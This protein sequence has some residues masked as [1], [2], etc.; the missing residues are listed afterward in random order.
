MLI[1]CYLSA[2]SDVANSAIV[3]DRQTARS[4]DTQHM[5]ETED[6]PVRQ[7]KGLIVQALQ[8]HNENNALVVVGETGSGKT[9]QVPQILLDGSSQTNLRNL[10]APRRIAVTQPRRVAAVS[11]AHRVASERNAWVGGEVGYSIRFDDKSSRNTKIKFATDGILLRE[12]LA[13]DGLL[14]QYGAVVVDEVHERTVQSDVL[15]GILRR[16]Q[17]ARQAQQSTNPLLLIVMSATLDT[18][19]FSEFLGNAKTVRIPG[20]LYP[21]QLLFTNEAQDDY[22]DAAVTTALQIH[23]DE[24]LGDVLV[25]LTG[26]D[27]IEA[28]ARRLREHVPKLKPHHYALKAVQLYAALAPEQQLDAFQPAPAGTRKVVF[29]TNIAET[30]VTISGIRYLQSY[31]FLHCTLLLHRRSSISASKPAKFPFLQ[32]HCYLRRYV[33]DTGVAKQRHFHPHTGIETLTVCPIS[34]AQVCR[35]LQSTCWNHHSHTR[36]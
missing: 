24:A 16:V 28:A 5:T 7:H 31:Y 14:Q 1:R 13:H 36:M 15:L 33:I 19:S 8:E 10:L 3:M 30:S 23:V 34:K 22:V 35:C 26:Q 21:V 2:I 27:E 17:H 25:F 6:L 11:V 4:H 20:R 12:A 9:T 29:A 32:P 18:A